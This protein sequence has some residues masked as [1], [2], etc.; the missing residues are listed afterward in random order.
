MVQLK[1]AREMAIGA[2]PQLCARGR[3]RAVETRRKYVPCRLHGAL[4]GAEGPADPYPTPVSVFSL[5]TTLI[6]REIPAATASRY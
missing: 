1:L 5:A 2:I 3:V 6:A 4:R